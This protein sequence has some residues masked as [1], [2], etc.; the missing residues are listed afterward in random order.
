MEKSQKLSL[1]IFFLLLTISCIENKEDP[2]KILEYGKRYQGSIRSLNALKKVT[3]LDSTNSEAYRELSIPYLKRGLPHLWKKYMD[4]SI[5]LNAQEWQGYRG[6]NYLWFYRDYKK[7]I[8]DFDASDTLTPNF[9]DAPQGHS[10]DYWRGIAY[11]GLKDYKNSIYYFDKHIEKETKETGEDWVEMTAYLY[12]G[13][14]HYENKNDSLA[15][16]SFDKLL[17]YTK[18]DFADGNYYKALILEKKGNYKTALELT[19]L[20][21]KNYEEGFYNYRAYVETLRQIY[22][23]DLLL[24]K[25]RL[26]KNKII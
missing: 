3:E 17:K 6:Y 9:I 5:A 16:L 25:E 21:I 8:A 18:N 1:S 14:A 7:A 15:L 4:K 26:T 20:A 11:L 24:L 12:E 23:E 22:P 13:I 10:V 2:V 19:N